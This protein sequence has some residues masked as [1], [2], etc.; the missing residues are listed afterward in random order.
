MAPS[1]NS[2]LE[3][4]AV[5]EVSTMMFLTA[6]M[7]EIKSQKEPTGSF[8]ITLI[9]SYMYLYKTSSHVCSEL[10]GNILWVL[11]IIVTG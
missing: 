5:N 8:K 2:L 1:F 9:H 6:N 11:V 4:F 10:A 3:P 7:V